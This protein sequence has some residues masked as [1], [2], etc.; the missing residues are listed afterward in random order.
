MWIALYI[1]GGLLILFII[2]E[3]YARFA[4]G[5]GDPPLWRFD[6][7]YEYIPQPSHRCKRFGNNISFNAWSMRSRDVPQNKTDSNELRVLV[8]GD[9]VVN[10]VP[11]IDQSDL[12]TTLLESRLA[13]SLKRPVWVGNVSAGSWG[14]P[15]LNA[16]VKRHGLFDCDAVVLVL[17]SADY[18]K[19]LQFLPLNVNRPSRKPP[20]ALWEIAGKYVRRAVRKQL[21]KKIRE[22]KQ[23][24][25]TGEQS[26]AALRELFPFLKKSGAAIVVLQHLERHEAMS[27]PDK[28]FAEQRE[29]AKSFGITPINLGAMFETAL[30]TGEDPYDDHI[31][32]NARGHEMLAVAMHDALINALN[33]STR[34]QPG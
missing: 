2:G 8:L 15:N 9:S 6:E 21:R 17:N 23:A 29:I 14:P 11:I 1:I 31:H 20:L 25:R 4:L 16:Y 18:F 27:Q 26:E 33:V 19:E 12:C 28:G 32:P 24:A 5:L 13:E 22:A 10:G 30:K 3:I 34:A 7:D